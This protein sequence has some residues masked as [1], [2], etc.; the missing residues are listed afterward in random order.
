MWSEYLNPNPTEYC[1]H[2][3]KETVH[4]QVDV[5]GDDRPV[6]VCKDCNK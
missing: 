2:C 3:D 5:D 4:E 1:D 6:I